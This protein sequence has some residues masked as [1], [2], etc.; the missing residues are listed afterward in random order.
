MVLLP[1]LPV[2][3]STYYHILSPL[4]LNFN[5]AKKRIHRKQPNFTDIKTLN[6]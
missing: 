5:L 1:V 2:Q 3:I 4:Y 6:Y